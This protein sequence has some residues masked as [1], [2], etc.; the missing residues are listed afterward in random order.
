MSATHVPVTLSCPGQFDY[1]N[2]VRGTAGVRWTEWLDDFELFINASGVKL[3]SQ[4]IS[5]LLHVADASVRR[6]YNASK[7]DNDKYENVV[8]ILNEHFK[9]MTNVNYFR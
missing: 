4:K 7:K 2:E 6:I 1:D 3:E 9:P 8:K 5:I